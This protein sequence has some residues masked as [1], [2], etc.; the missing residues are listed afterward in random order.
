MAP[1]RVQGTLD[2]ADALGT[3]R[4]AVIGHDW[5]TR[6]AYSLAALAPD[7]ATTICALALAYQPNGRFVMPDFAQAQALGTSG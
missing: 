3:G 7:R 2:P 4:F 6:T 5:G 1:S